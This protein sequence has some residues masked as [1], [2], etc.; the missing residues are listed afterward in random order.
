MFWKGNKMNLSEKIINEYD[1]WQNQSKSV[2]ADNIE[3]Y[4]FKKYPECKETFND[5]INQLTDIT[6]DKKQTGYSWLNRSRADV[7]TPFIKL[8]RIAAALDV[9]ISDMLEESNAN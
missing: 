6:G 1:K 7:K 5:K 8:C 2:I 3:H 4:L 9:D